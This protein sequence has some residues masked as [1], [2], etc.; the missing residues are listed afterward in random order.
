[1]ADPTPNENI[2]A[3]VPPHHHVTDTPPASSHAAPTAHFT[4]ADWDVFRAEDFAAGKAVV[5]LMLAIFSMGVVLYSVV[6]Y[7]VATTS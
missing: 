2:T 5:I 1:M 7:F 4:E 3:S 6:A